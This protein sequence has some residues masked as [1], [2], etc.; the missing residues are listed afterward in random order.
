MWELKDGSGLTPREIPK[1]KAEEAAAQ[2]K[3]DAWRPPRLSLPIQHDPSKLLPVFT[4]EVLRAIE[5]KSTDQTKTYIVN[6]L[7]YTC[8]CPLCLEIHSGVPS[9]DFGRICKH[10]IIALRGKYLVSQLPPIA[11]GIA[12][13]GYPYAAFGVYP[14][15]FAN[16][17]NGNPIYITGKNQ[18]GWINVFALTRRDGVNYFRYGFNVIRKS[19]CRTM[20]SGGY[21][22]APP[23]I[24]ESILY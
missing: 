21:N 15:R 14:G 6:L 17:L 18:D 24:D 3:R 22:W 4:S 19:W 8:T 9:R 7:D 2:A 12:E 16:D 13:N 20:E 10:I 1:R 23:K 5:V 11:K